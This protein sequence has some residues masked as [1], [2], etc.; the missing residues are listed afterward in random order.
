MPRASGSVEAAAAGIID[1]VNE[2]MFGALRLVSVQQGFD[3]RDLRA[4]GGVT[5]QLLIPEDRWDIRLIP[6]VK[7]GVKRTEQKE[8]TA[9]GRHLTEEEFARLDW[10]NPYAAL[11]DA[12]SKV[13]A[14]Q[15]KGR[16]L[17]EEA[18]E[19]RAPHPVDR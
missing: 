16:E 12:P 13:T 10:V 7:P 17:D 8:Q 15:L 2:N 18:A 19:G 14:T 3:P 9:G 1:I 6:A 5:C 11:A 4:A